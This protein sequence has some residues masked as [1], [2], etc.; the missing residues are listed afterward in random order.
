MEKATYFYLLR[1]GYFGGGAS[2][3]FSQFGTPAAAYSL[4]S[5]NGTNG[6]VIRVRRSSDDTEQDFKEPE[7]SGGALLSFVGLE[8]KILQ[9][10]NFN[11]SPWAKTAG[12]SISNNPASPPTGI[13]DSKIVTFTG[14]SESLYQSVTH[15]AGTENN[16]IYIKGTGGETIS[17]GRGANIAQGSIFTLDGTWQRINI[18]SATGGIFQINTYNGATARTIELTAVQI[19]TGSGVKSYVETTTGESGLGF[20]TAFYD[21]SGNG[22]HAT[23]ATASAQPKIVNAGALVTENGLAAI[24]FDG[25]DDFI[26]SDLSG[27]AISDSYFVMNYENDSNAMSYTDLYS[28]SNTRYSPYVKSS[29]GSSAVSGYG[30]PSYYVNSNLVTITTRTEAFNE[31]SSGKGQILRVD[32][33]ADTS[34]WQDLQFGFWF[35]GFTY[36]GTLQEWVIYDTDKS[37]NREAIEANINDHYT[38]Y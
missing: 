30:S 33:G 38:I 21:Q 20:V 23:Q 12:V 27:S 9:S 29:E 36:S 19:T 16:S 28:N 35:S 26:T 22:N 8:N 4:R 2:S 6:N 1:R 24:K 15:S 32:Q 10:Q 13:T 11:A 5:L 3:F 18:D 7:I 25:V 37:G 31:F 17:F 14:A 34:T